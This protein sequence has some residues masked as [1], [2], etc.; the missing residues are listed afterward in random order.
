MSLIE[1]PALFVA[2]VTAGLVGGVA[3]LASVVSYPALLATGLSPIS[4]NVTNTAALVFSGIGSTV[5]SRPELRGQRRRARVLGVTGLAGGLLGAVL[6]LLTPSDAF[7]KLVPWLIGF[8]SVAILLR[9]PPADPSG[10][11]RDRPWVI[12]SVFAIAVYGGYFGAA[13]GV[14]L[15]AL[16]L[17]STAETLP[18]SNAMKNLV[19]GGANLVA[20]G[21]FALTGQVHW[22]AALPLALGF[23]C[24]GVLSPRVVRRLPVRPLRVLIALAGTAI[25][26][27]L[28]I[29]AY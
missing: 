29:Q 25:A 9:R 4:A 5:G 19:M 24:G 13:S 14:L 12:G 18:Q 20:A 15:L 7:A 28:A 27:R 16:L 2:G 1:G 22:L 21:V 8:G 6:L 10:P 17:A 23:F 26:I 3:G 11:T